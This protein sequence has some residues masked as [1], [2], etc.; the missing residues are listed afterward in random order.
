LNASRG[1]RP[2][3]P[4]SIEELAADIAAILEREAR[5]AAAAGAAVVQVDEPYLADVD[6]VRDDAVLAAELDSK[7]LSAA[8]AAGAS[9]R[10]AV[11][12]NVPEPTVYEQ[13]LNVKA[14]YLVVDVADAPARALKLLEEKGTPSGL[15]LGVVQARGIYPEHYGTVKPWLEKAAALGPERM[16][17]TTSAWLDLIPL[18]YAVQKTGI[19]GHIAAHARKDFAS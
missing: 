9:T 3:L 2:P 19:L 5:L 8:A 7:I 6:A 15:G 16:L 14:D 13:L 12:Y 1:P 10:L 18:S 11:E 17:L 4:K